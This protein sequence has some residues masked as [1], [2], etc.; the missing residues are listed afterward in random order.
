MASEDTGEAA[1]IAVSEDVRRWL[2]RRADEHGVDVGQ[3]VRLLLAAHRDLDDDDGA[4]EG[5]STDAIADVDDPVDRSELDEVESEF[6]SLLEDVRSR[7]IQV[8]READGKAPAEHGHEALESDLEELGAELTALDE[9]LSTH[10]DRLESVEANLDD[11]FENFEEV[12]EYLIEVTDDLADRTDRLAQATIGTREQLQ[13]LAGSIEEREAA[14][15]LKR[16][17]ALEG[18]EAADCEDCGRSVRAGLLTSPDCPYC[19]AS[20]VDVEPKQGFFG[21]ATF[22]TGQ[23][24][25]LTGSN[26]DPVAEALQADVERDRPHPADVD[27]DTAGDDDR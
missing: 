25:A 2:Q 17:A 26:D 8:K 13:E 10:G 21:S 4:L 9:Q 24:P 3:F 23:S 7:V 27:W 6:R 1:G 15:R 20:F 19:A 12:L 11:G 22:V 16:D 18:I 5:L 14:D